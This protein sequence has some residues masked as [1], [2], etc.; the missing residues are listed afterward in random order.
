[1]IWMANRPTATTPAIAAVIPSSKLKPAPPRCTAVAALIWPHSQLTAWS[2]AWP[3]DSAMALKASPA[4]A[5]A[6]S[7]AHWP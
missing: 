7:P 2:A 3:N 5:F 1:M 6:A 4:A